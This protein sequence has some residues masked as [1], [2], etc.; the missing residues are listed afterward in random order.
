MP[1]DGKKGTLIAVQ[2][3]AQHILKACVEL[4]EQ[5]ASGLG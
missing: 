3:G 2:S 1:L 5:A 4:K